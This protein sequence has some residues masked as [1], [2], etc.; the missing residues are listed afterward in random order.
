MHGGAN[1]PV[2]AF[3]PHPFFAERAGGSHLFDVEG[4][5]YIDYCLAYGPLILGHAHRAL[6]QNLLSQ[7]ILYPHQKLLSMFR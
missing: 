6:L 4:K 2:R 5:E 1:S 3:Q 7:I